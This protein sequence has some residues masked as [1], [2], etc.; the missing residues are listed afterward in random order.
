MKK[1][2]SFSI[3]LLFVLLVTLNG[4][5]QNCSVNANVDLS[6]CA[7]ETMLLIGQKAGLFEGSGT[8]TWSQ[9]EGPS[10]IITNPNSLTTTVTGFT[11][12]NTY[13]FRLST[14]CKDGSLTYDDV[15]YTVKPITQSNSGADMTF[16][17]G[18]AVGNM[19]ANAVGLNET[20]SW[21]VIG[22]NNGITLANNNSPTSSINVANNKSG[23]TTL[24]WTIN[25]TNGCLSKDTVVIINRGGV[26]PVDAGA[27]KIL[28]NCYSTTQSVAMTASFGGSGIDGQIGT[29]TIISGPNIPTISNV[30]SN[31][32]NVSNLI[33]GTYTLRWTVSGPCVNG[34]DDVQIVVPPPTSSVTTASIVGGNQTFCDGR[35]STVLMGKIPTYINEVV[36]WTKTSGHAVNIESPNNPVTNITGLNGSSSYTFKYTITNVFTGCSSSASVTVSYAT[37]ATL[38]ISTPQVILPCAQ[39]FVS[40]PYTTSG[41]GTVQ[42]SIISGPK[43]PT[44]STIPTSWAN[45]SGSPLTIN[46]LTVSG[47]YVIR[48]RKSSGTGNEC[49]TVTTDVTV[50]V[51]QNPTASNSGT[52][53]V[54]ACNVTQTALAGNDPYVGVG[55]WTQV[56]GPNTAIIDSV[57]KFNSGIS[58]LTNG[59]YVFRWLISGGPYCATK[60]TDVSVI[61][62]STN[63]TQADAGHDQNVCINTPV[64]LSANTPLLNETGSWSVI[65]STGVTFSNINSPNAIVNGLSANTTYKFVWKIENACNFNTDSIT[66]KTNNTVGSVASNA[67]PDQ[68][69]PSGTT[70]ITLA[71]NNPNGGIGTWTKLSGNQANITN[72]NLQ[73]TSVTGLTDGTYTFEW[74]ILTNGACLP[75]R[76]TVMVTISALTSIANA[77]LDQQICGNSAI[78]LANNPTVGIGQWSQATGH[79]GANI[80]NPTSNSTLVSGLQNGV[81]QFVWTISNNACPSKSDTIDIYVTNPPTTPNAGADITVCGYDTT[82]LNANVISIG[83]GSWSVISGPNS[84]T[85]SNIY[86]PKT[87]VSG[88]ITGTYIFRWSSHNGPFCPPS[89]DDVEVKVVL[90]ANAGANQSYCESTTTVNLAGNNPSVGTWSQVSGP[91]NSTITKTSD[92]TATASG[93]IPGIYTFRYTISEYGC[94]STSDMTVTLYTPPTI[95]DAGLDQSVCAKDTIFLNGNTPVSGT[96]LWTKLSGPTGGTFKPNANTPNAIFTGATTG[97][98]VFVWTISNQTCSNADQVIVKNFA[99]PSNANAGT[100]Q[101]VVCANSTIMSANL[102]SVG[103][104]NWT[105]LNGPNTPNIISTILPNTTINNLVPGTYNL[106]WSISNGVCPVKKDTVALIVYQQPSPANAGPDQNLCEQTSTTLNAVAPIIGNGTWTQVSGPNTAI[107]DNPS[108]SN[109]LISGLTYGSYVF[110]WTTSLPPCSSTD[111]V[112]INISQ[113]PTIAYAGQDINNCLFSPLFLN[114]NTPLVG[115]GVW[116]QISGP[117]NANILNPNSNSSNVIGVISGNYSFAWKISNGSCN[118]SIDTVN[119]V[120]SDIPTMAVAGID[121]EHCN[122][123]TLNLNGNTP[124][125]GT[126]TWSQTSGPSVNIVNN[127]SPNALVINVVPGNYSFKWEISNNFCTSQDEVFAIVHALPTNSNAGS[128]LEYCN[129]NSFTLNANTPLN[130]TGTWSKVSGPAA[131]ITNPNLPNT[132]VTGVTTGTYVFRWS[133]TSGTCT[134]SIS[135]VTVINYTNPTIANAGPNQNICSNSVIMNA[136][137]P[138]LGNTG[139]WSQVS[140]PNNANILNINQSNT[141]INNLIQGT[142]T[143]RWSITNGNCTP[144]YSDV[145]IN[146]YENPTP[147]NAGINQS[148]CNENNVT[149]NGNQPAIGTG[150][151]SLITGPNTP[152]IVNPSNYNTLVNGLTTGTY[153]FKWTINNGVCSPSSSQVTIINNPLP[154]IANA[155]SPQSLCNANGVTLNGNIPSVGTGIWSLVSGPNTPT[156][157]SP[158]LNSTY[159]NGLDTGV[160]IFRWTISNANCTLSYSDV[161]ITNFSLP[162]VSFAGTNQ[163]F[164][165]SITS[166]NLNG[167]IPNYGSGLWTQVSGP[168]NA[169]IT[170]PNNNS[171]TINGL[172]MGQ[173]VFRWTISNGN[174]TPNSSDVTVELINCIPVA[175]NDTNS[176]IENTPVSGNILPNDSDP[177]SDTLQVTSFVIN[178][179]TY[180]A[181]TST[182]IPG[183]GSIT[184]N[185]D[186]SYTFVPNNYWSGVVPNIPYSISDGYGGTAIA[187]L[188]ITVTP[189]PHFIDLEVTKLLTYPDP[190]IT[191]S[192]FKNDTVT[193]TI[194]LKNNSSILN[195]SNIVVLDTLPNS[196]T[197]IA[198]TVSSGSYDPLTGLWTLSQLNTNDSAYMTIT[199]IVD[200]SGQNDVYILSQNDNDTIVFNNKSFASVTITNTSSG[201]DGGIESNGNMASKLALRKFLRHKEKN[202]IFDNAL[203][204]EV[205]TGDKNKTSRLKSVQSTDLPNF[206]PQIG[207]VNST[208]YI[209]TPTDLIGMTNAIEVIS[210]DYFKNTTTRNAA[211]L[212]FATPAGTIYEHTKLVCDRL[213]GATLTNADYITINGKQFIITRLVQDNGDV[214]YAVSFIAY[215]NGNTY[216]IDNQW[217]IDSYL[218][219]TNQ[220]VLNYQVWSK[221]ERYTVELIEKMFNNMIS[222]GFS[223][224]FA[225]STAPVMPGVY[226]KNGFYKDGNI[227]MD[228]TNNNGANSISFNGTKALIENGN[229]IP[230]ANATSINTSLQSQSSVY[231]G[232]V[233]DI[234]FSISNNIGGGKDVIYFADGPWGYECDELG[235]SISDF[236]I[237]PQFAQLNPSNYNL[238]RTSYLEGTVKTY[239]SLYRILRVGNKPVNLT[240]YNAIEFTASGVGTFE[241]VVS[242]NSITSWN[243][244]YR[245]NIT[246]SN[247][248]TTFTIP[249]SQLKNSMGQYNFNANDVVA[250]VFVRKGNGTSYQNFS[251]NVGNLKFIN[252]VGIKE[253]DNNNKIS[254]IEVYPNPFNSYTTVT[255][256]LPKSEKVKIS[257]LDVTGKLINELK[258]NY[259]QSGINRE[260][261]SAEGLKQGVYFIK[262]ETTN[263]T[264]YNK[265]VLIK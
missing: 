114:A 111:Q 257:I 76:D 238:P 7:N 39:T 250:V 22:T 224:Q 195:A 137:T 120:V 221:S 112:V 108:S 244:Q 168:N 107:I 198:S 169:N 216:T 125:V 153:V 65:P 155:G 255:F 124:M 91:N 161:T 167:N 3:L 99:M 43:T 132:T 219:I 98:Y 230:Y 29:W 41:S 233:F 206:I 248:P 123:T 258:E 142:Y 183:I 8:T 145:T 136:N 68:C 170:N 126:G 207:P 103:I 188:I 84:P 215:K 202:N 156:I 150:T 234:G 10:V 232:Y 97:T 83:T 115:T 157:I 189:V 40:I 25:N 254:N 38:T 220:P 119:V 130:G 213:D 20:G 15:V 1:Y 55:T 21:S 105:I 235:A 184:I 117:N 228:L 212:G 14:V 225:N 237:T 26:S 82:S 47:T 66:I 236:S 218:P 251:I 60:Q 239:A 260:T 253:P 205:F 147:S 180:L 191:D 265:V 12:G 33:Q 209:S 127:N 87:K 113:N 178:G 118:A 53:Q 36:S 193:F 256:N 134:P 27:D 133:I 172:V 102:P 110:N 140:G 63:P 52:K 214:D 59:M 57:N 75:T 190:T 16:C 44:Y 246:L 162:D 54:L 69:L 42:W 129:S 144:S 135:E 5:T 30:N 35:T 229:R 240:N 203:N 61:V 104:G 163:S 88:L 261:I 128:N 166:T 32:T 141:T 227:Y 175:T 64:Y 146:V 226:V 9:V 19:A 185:G 242:K 81:Y 164:C 106:E 71:G 86:N 245:T 89:F 259:Y 70:S 116:S 179:I 143:F 151:W 154:S 74:S 31:T 67:G 73:N 196:F 4:K 249:L 152:N 223:L 72:P 181:G 2:L 101:S 264:Y 24:V 192:I 51:S 49:N 199:A 201:N 138:G 160:Y 94:N 243:N 158:S 62:V 100:D 13:K 131:N 58:G 186:G 204:L 92:N 93:L 210:V 173:Y 252:T 171:T 139:T 85:I 56:S 50:V 247:T 77:G 90:P 109:T 121:Q 18:N 194:I 28:T 6:L 122:A 174:C 177:D 241:L 182:T 262:L 165:K 96:G 23:A 263:Y 17:P 159:V 78:L 34:F 200:T 176:T 222:K 46:G 197:Y 11:G 148:L 217:D 48:L 231:T 208:A 37:P 149:L 45:S 80:S 79:G 95:P 211:I 187:E